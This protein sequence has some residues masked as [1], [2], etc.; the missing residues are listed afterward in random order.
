MFRKKNDPSKKKGMANSLQ[1]RTIDDAHE[2]DKSRRHAFTRKKIKR[3]EKCGSE[4]E[5]TRKSNLCEACEREQ[6]Q[7]NVKKDAAVA[8]AIGLAKVVAPYVKK[9]V[10]VMA[11][12]AKKISIIG[13]VV[14]VLA[15]IGGACGMPSSAR[16]PDSRESPGRPHVGPTRT[17]TGRRAGTSPR[18]PIQ[19][20]S[21]ED[22]LDAPTEKL[23]DRP[24]KTF[25]YRKSN[26]AM[27]E[28]G[29]Y[30]MKSKPDALDVHDAVADAIA[31][32]D[33]ERACK[34]M[35][36][37]VDEVARVLNFLK[38]RNSMGDWC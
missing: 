34:A 12:A 17:P 37:I 7:N 5:S 9:A 4:L 22:H 13:A 36:G 24:R 31:K 28:L 25:G 19:T 11:R 2:A 18:A 16:W 23:N 38:N 29:K 15:I 30:P 26:E 10:P 14:V 20:S 3:C 33:P 32:G 21:P 6:L 27:M 8:A 1:E 35:F